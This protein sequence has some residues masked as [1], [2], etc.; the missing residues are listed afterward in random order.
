MRVPK[1]KTRTPKSE[2]EG[3]DAAEAYFEVLGLDV[4]DDAWL[5]SA[6]HV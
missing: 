1:P 5:L 6:L 3:P 2:F 4:W